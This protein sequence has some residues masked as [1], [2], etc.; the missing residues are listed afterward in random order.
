MWGSSVFEKRCGRLINVLPDIQYAAH[1]DSD[2]STL[3]ATAPEWMSV[4][5]CPPRAPSASNPGPGLR[6]SGRA[7]DSEQESGGAVLGLALG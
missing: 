2:G 3:H 4:F 1:P 5:S 7:V 6:S